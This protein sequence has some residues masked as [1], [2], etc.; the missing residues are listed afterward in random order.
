MLADKEAETAA[1]KVAIE[2]RYEQMASEEGADVK[3]LAEAR[4]KEID[5]LARRLGTT[6]SPARLTSN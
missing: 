1:A 6:E 3:V 4:T 5:E 2:A